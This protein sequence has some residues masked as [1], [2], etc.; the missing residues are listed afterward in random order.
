M[1]VFSSLFLASYAEDVARTCANALDAADTFVARLGQPR[2]TSKRRSHDVAHMCPARLPPAFLLH[3]GPYI[4]GMA[5]SHARQPGRAMAVEGARQTADARKTAPQELLDFGASV[6]PAPSFTGLFDQTST[7]AG[8]AHGCRNCGASRNPPSAQAVGVAFD[9][10]SKALRSRKP[11]QVDADVP[12]RRQGV[13]F[14]GL[15][16]ANKSAGCSVPV[17]VTMRICPDTAAPWIHTTHT[18]G[19]RH[20]LSRGRVNLDIERRTD[21]SAVSARMPVSSAAAFVAATMRWNPGR[22]PMGAAT[23]R[24]AAHGFRV[25]TPLDAMPLRIRAQVVAT[26][27]LRVRQEVP[28]HLLQVAPTPRDRRR[29]KPP[30]TS[31]VDLQ[32]NRTSSTPHSL[33]PPQSAGLST[34]P[35]A[36]RAGTPPSPRGPSQVLLRPPEPRQQCPRRSNDGRK[37]PRPATSTRACPASLVAECA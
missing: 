2:T 19:S 10:H 25:C 17:D 28:R 22:S 16:S 11:F 18:C 31:C 30:K 3:N 32:V 13:S 36:E 23:G 37:A 12:E 26:I 35:P 29:N 14:V 6:A 5:A 34:S 9:P 27:H 33:S 7:I 21:L 8:A 4:Q 20:R 24:F 15:S 1:L